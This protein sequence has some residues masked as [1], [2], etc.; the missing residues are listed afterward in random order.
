[1]LLKIVRRFGLYESRCNSRVGLNR[2]W[3]HSRLVVF[4]LTSFI[5]LAL[6]IDPLHAS[7]LHEACKNENLS[8]AKQAVRGG[9]D[10]N[11]VSQNGNTPLMLVA[12]SDQ[13]NIAEYLLKHGANPN[14]KIMLG[15]SPLFAAANTGHTAMTELLI[16]Y[17]ANV[18]IRT[19]IGVT[20][21]MAAAKYDHE[22]TVELLLKKG[23]TVT[24]NNDRKESALHYAVK[25]SSLQAI[26]PLLKMD[27]VVNRRNIQGKTPLHVSARH[28]TNPKII[29]VLLDHGANP[30]LHDKSGNHALT[31]ARDNDA[32][33]DSDAFKRLKARTF[34]G[35]W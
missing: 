11:A 2:S 25:G 27:T 4:V 28:A 26:P 7:A 18:N 17:G 15:L 22:A 13:Q 20:P 3:F 29:T 9:H 16:D 6:S 30:N 33:T 21:L 19:K 24:A 23:A 1:M 10:P 32:L 14:K 8:A 35:S 12:Q 34:H 31:Y 5:L